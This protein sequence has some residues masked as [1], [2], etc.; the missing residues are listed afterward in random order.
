MVEAKRFYIE[1]QAKKTQPPE[2]SNKSRNR[3]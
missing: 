3:N 1:D 2:E